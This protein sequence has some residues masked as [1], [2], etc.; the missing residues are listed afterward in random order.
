MACRRCAGLLVFVLSACD[1]GSIQSL[2]GGPDARAASVPDGPGPDPCI[3]AGTCPLGVWTNV[4]PSTMS[5]SVLA[6][7]FGPGGVAGDPARASDLY[8][9]G[10]GDG[11][12]KSVDY[13]KTWTQIKKDVPYSAIGL[14][15]AVAG[16]SPATVWVSSGKG[17]GS[18]FKSTDGGST[19]DLVGGDFNDNLYSLRV[20]PG[21]PQHLL[22]GLHEQDGLV[23]STDGG[24]HWRVVGGTGWPAGGKSWFPFFIDTGTRATTSL[25]WFA[26][27]Q[28]GASAAITRDGGASWTI[29]TGIEGLQHPHGC[30][31]I[32]QDGATL[33]AAG[34]YGPGQGV[35]RSTDTG[36]TFARVDP[37]QPQAV[38]WGTAKQVYSM[39]G[40]ACSDCAF[41]NFETAALPGTQ[42]AQI[43]LPQGIGPTNVAVTHDG[44]H[45]IFVGVM[46][47]AGIW[48]Y[49]EP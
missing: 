33:F 39:W 47:S 17:D 42:W 10:G 30:S 21:D 3:G 36:A 41:D 7:H 40:W 25:T 48:R 13:G 20:D 35:Y 23:E 32:Y 44:T 5:P 11:V 19:W 43:A 4:T 27:A 2:P 46:W 26:I 31:Q 16:T 12:W 49:I 24:A 15:I 14:T 8:V 22:S 34:I 1:G 6:G 37:G 38:V 9:G 28:D 18:L 45:A 29:P